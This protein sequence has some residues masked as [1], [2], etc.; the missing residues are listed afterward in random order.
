VPRVCRVGQ[1]S[2]GLRV[3]VAPSG[4]GG[5]PAR[6]ERLGCG[7]TPGAEVVQWSVAVGMLRGHGVPRT[8]RLLRAP[9]R[10]QLP[11]SFWIGATRPGW[12]QLVAR[13]SVPT[14]R[15]AVPKDKMTEKEEKTLCFRVPGDLRAP[16][17]ALLGFSGSPRQLVKIASLPGS[18]L[19]GLGN[20]KK[21][22]W[23]SRFPAKPPCYRSPRSFPLSEVLDL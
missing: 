5:S 9:C 19:P 20:G 12:A 18:P 17:L 14:W 2:A 16:E 21:S 7:G 4:G 10:A 8:A 23:M 3:R 15:L 1:V 11:V 6:A 22:G 13:G